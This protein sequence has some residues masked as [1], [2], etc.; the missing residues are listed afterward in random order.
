MLPHGWRGDDATVGS[1]DFRAPHDGLCLLADLSRDLVGIALLKAWQEQLDRQRTRVALVRQ[2][3]QHR[4]QWRDALAG[5]ESGGVV[6]QFSR[7]VGNVLEVHVPD[8]AW[9]D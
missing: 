2:L 5:N 3:A 6:E 1:E 8:L 7:H 9:L 4:V